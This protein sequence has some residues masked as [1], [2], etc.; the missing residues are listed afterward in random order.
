MF[1]WWVS[2]APGSMKAV[3]LMSA[4]QFR[5]DDPAPRGQSGELLLRALW[6]T[7]SSRPVSAR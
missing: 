6:S 5:E 2:I 7:R 1:E 3:F 4:V